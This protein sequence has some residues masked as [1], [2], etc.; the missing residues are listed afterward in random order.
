[1]QDNLT[2]KIKTITTGPVHPPRKKTLSSCH[3]SKLRNFEL[4]GG[5]NHFNCSRL[6]WFH[7]P[8]TIVD[9]TIEMP[10]P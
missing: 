2:Q 10:Q 9:V 1:M 7:T 8:G 6:C 3:I 4:P 5:R